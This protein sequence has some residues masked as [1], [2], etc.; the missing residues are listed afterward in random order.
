MLGS[1]VTASNITYTG[2]ARAAGTFDGTG[3]VLGL[4]GGILLTTGE[5]IRSIG[6]DDSD[7]EGAGNAGGGDPDLF[8]LAS[9]FPI[10]DAKRYT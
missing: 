4:N 1:C 6:P 10:N 8:V 3:T 2:A 5:A 9:G 7:S